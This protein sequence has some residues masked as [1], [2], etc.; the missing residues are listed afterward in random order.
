[1]EN[2][3]VKYKPTNINDC[4]ISDKN[5]SIINRF[6][7]NNSFANMIFAGNIGCGKSTVIDIITKN[8]KDIDIQRLNV[9]LI[10]VKHIFSSLE[11]IVAI[12]KRNGKRTLFIINDFHILK[13]KIQ[14]N[15]AILLEK[16]RNDSLFFIETTNILE[17]VP[18]IQNLMIIIKF[19]N[20][21]KNQYVSFVNGICDKENMKVDNKVINQLSIITNGDIK[22][23][24]N[25]L[26]ALKGIGDNIDNE[27]F[28][29][30]FGIPSSVSINKIIN[31]IIECNEELV[32]NECD[33]LIKE[34]FDCNEIM[35]KLFN[36]IIEEDI[37]EDD[38]HKLL[39]KLGKKIYKFN[40]YQESNDKLKVY[41]ESLL[42][43]FK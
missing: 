31:G 18:Q 32:L 25:Y 4:F 37:D 8:I 5:K 19:D 3:N 15:F 30:I 1:M 27:M 43:L 35:I 17:I 16:V 24:L 20:M 6:I 28:E 33:K 22:C 40:K 36:G 21:N 2:F 23:T 12:N 10:D 9:L 34:K 41:V 7:K 14:I 38:K 11:R 29:S 13:P 26:T 42:D 39:E